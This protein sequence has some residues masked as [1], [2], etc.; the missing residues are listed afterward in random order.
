MKG[1]FAVS[2][3][4]IVAIAACGKEKANEKVDDQNQTFT[5]PTQPAL[6]AIVGETTVTLTSAATD[7]HVS[8]MGNAAPRM[9]NFPQVAK[10][11][12]KVRGFVCNMKGEPIAGANVS[13]RTGSGIYILSEATTN[14]Q[15]Y[16]EVNAFAGCQISVASCKIQY[17]NSSTATAGLALYPTDQKISVSQAEASEGIV[18]NWVR[19][20]YGPGDP[21]MR[22]NQ[23]KAPEGHA[24]GSVAFYYLGH[25][26]VLEPNG[27]AAGNIEIKLR[28]VA[29]KMLDE[30]NR[31]FNIIK[32]TEGT[33]G[34]IFINDIP[35]GQYELSVKLNGKSLKMKHTDLD[36]SGYPAHGLFPR[37]AT[38]TAQLFFIPRVTDAV[39]PPL[40]GFAKQVFLT[41]SDE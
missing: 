4:G 39:S 5:W 36:A 11:P 29:G 35:L 26:P 38:G 20:T 1:I 22:A 19:T 24:G 34:L 16:Y 32:R 23:P 33:D 12:G 10:K 40:T 28:P 17:G 25:H 18:K 37:I 13:S 2:M 7:D 41:L 6:P 14:Q 27:L 9:P 21:D 15:G 8:V 30:V 31:T 3:F